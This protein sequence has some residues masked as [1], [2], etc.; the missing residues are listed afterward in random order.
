MTQ[1]IFQPE[2]L[3]GYVPPGHTGTANTRLVDGKSVDGQYEMILGTVQAGGAASRHRHE[4]QTQVVYVLD[5]KGLAELGNS[6]PVD[7]GPGSVVII[8]PGV[9]HYMENTSDGVMHVIVVY[10]P[11]LTP[12]P[13][14]E[15]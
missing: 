14:R 12:D 6:P 9:E 5:G 15:S 3:P 10:S 11:P 7:V 2:E 8:P 13:K 4:V 1:Y